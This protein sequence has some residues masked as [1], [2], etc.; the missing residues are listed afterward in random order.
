MTRR[1]SLASRE[2][3]GKVRRPPRA[4]PTLPSPTEVTR[5][6]DAALAGMRD[7]VWSSPLGWLYLSGRL[8]G[9]QFAAG[10][11]WATLARDYSAATQSP[12]Q[13]RSANLDPAG[14]QPPDPDSPAGLKEAQQHAHTLHQYLAALEMLKH[15]GAPARRAVAAVCEQATMPAGHAQLADLN[16]GLSALSAFWNGEKRK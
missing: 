10:R 4:D 13:P 12:K 6:R 2:P 11:R 16:R 7:A 15:T 9:S 14:G 1:K 8:S 5:L 3:S